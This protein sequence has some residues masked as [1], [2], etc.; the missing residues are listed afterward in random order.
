MESAL[1]TFSALDPSLLPLCVTAAGETDRGLRR[2][3]NE[4]AVLLR[5]DLGLYIVA[6]GAGGQD[7]GNVA[8]ALAATTVAKYFDQTEPEF[9]SMPEVDAHGLWTGARRVSAAVQRA[10]MAVVEIAQAANKYR[11]M[12]TTIVCALAVPRSGRLHV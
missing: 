3:C 6:D 4:D 11:G 5:A 1:S 9:A 10:N 8:S 2:S 7:A 12:G